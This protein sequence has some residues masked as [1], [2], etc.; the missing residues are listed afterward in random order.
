[1]K[2]TWDAMCAVAEQ[3]V[4]QIM[5]G[6][7]PYLRERVGNVPVIFE[8][9]PSRAMQDDGFEA[10]TLGL[11]TGAEWAELGE[12]VVP[13]Q[14]ILYLENLWEAAERDEKRFGVEIRT[15]FLHELG[16]FLGLDEDDL[17][18]RGLE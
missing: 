8:R 6:L 12:V 10:D 7:P 15:T 2:L 11:F 14:V 4:R 5:D 3:E 17:R 1:M 9:R 16:H 13:A 18:E